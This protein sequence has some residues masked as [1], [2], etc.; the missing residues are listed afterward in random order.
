[1]VGAL[2]GVVA[3]S[4]SS[5]HPRIQNNILVGNAEAGIRSAT[6][7][8]QHEDHNLLFDNAGDGASGAAAVLV[9]DGPD[10]GVYSPVSPAPSDVLADPM[11]ADA[12]G[13]DMAPGPAAIDVGVDLGH[14]RNGGAPG[15]FNGS[16]P[17]LGAV[18]TP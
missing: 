10:A 12:P 5:N 8:S 6:N 2:A 9:E 7:T 16:A 15:L 1:M 11:L 3:Y 17:D 14:D 13:G 4:T 18:E